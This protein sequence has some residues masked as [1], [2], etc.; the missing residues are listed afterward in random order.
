MV[1]R[2]KTA[3]KLNRTSMKRVRG[4]TGAGVLQLSAANTYRG[5]TSVQSDKKLTPAALGSI[6]PCL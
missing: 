5:T 6:Q 4:G 1:A 2:K 3:R